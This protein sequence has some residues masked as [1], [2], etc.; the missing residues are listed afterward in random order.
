MKEGFK[1]LSLFYKQ[2]I[3]GLKPKE[4]FTKCRSYIIL[5]AFCHF[6]F[7]NVIFFRIEGL[8]YLRL[9]CPFLCF[10]LFKNYFYVY[11]VILLHPILFKS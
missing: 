8:A 2:L 7:E 3:K 6:Y 5:F 1:L 4:R 11:N 10:L 9:T